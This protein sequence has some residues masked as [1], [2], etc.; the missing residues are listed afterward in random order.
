M[1]LLSMAHVTVS[2]AV[3]QTNTL[4]RQLIR[5]DGVLLK[6]DRGHALGAVPRNAV[7][8]MAGTQPWP[9]CRAAVSSLCRA[10]STTHSNAGHS[11]V[12]PIRRVAHFSLTPVMAAT[13]AILPTI[14]VLRVPML[15]AMMQWLRA[16]AVGNAVVPC[17]ANA[18]C[19]RATVATD[20]Y[21][22][23]PVAY[24]NGHC[25]RPAQWK[26]RWKAIMPRAS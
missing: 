8:R 16:H 13:V 7:W 17:A 15:A 20:Q 19:K 26:Q 3:G 23:G 14:G 4:V 12:L 9:R 24:G 10:I 2:D 5:A 6:A 11:T 22:A 18:S 21:A 1:A 25:K